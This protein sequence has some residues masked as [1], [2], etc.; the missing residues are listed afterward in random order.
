MRARNRARH[1]E[2]VE[3]E[4][5]ILERLDDEYIDLIALADA[6]AAMSEVVHTVPS[7]SGVDAAFVGKPSSNETLILSNLTGFRTAA[8]KDLVVGPGKG[9]AGSVTALRR[10]VWVSDYLAASLI[11]HDYDE[12]VSIEGLHGMI[13]VPIVARDRILGI[14]YGACRREVTFGDQAAEVMID[15]A[16]KTAAAV[17]AAERAGTPPRSQYTKSDSDSR[18]RARQRRCDAVRDQRGSTRCG[19]CNAAGIG[20]GAALRHRAPGRRG[21][22]RATRGTPRAVGVTRATRPHRRA[23][24]RL[25]HLSR[26]HRHPSPSR[27]DGRTTGARPGPHPRARRHSSRGAA[28]RREAPQARSV[29]VTAYATD[30]GIA[31][32]VADDGSGLDHALASSDG[33]GLGIAAAHDRL[34]RLG[35]NLS[36]VTNDDGGVTVKS[37]VPL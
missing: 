24:C 35:G 17:F 36:L 11:T 37:W 12:A 25:S 5:E 8:M 6:D 33:L 31:L 4:I 3:A 18:S 1:R 7:R 27:R 14:L 16:K 21:R 23:A 2:R 10:P 15:A 29:V 30:N 13:A 22:R 28:Q 26:P 34:S 9:L 19:W 20:A 32:A